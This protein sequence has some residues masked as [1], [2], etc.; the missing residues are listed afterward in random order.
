VIEL[1]TAI[2]DVNELL[3]TADRKRRLAAQ[4]ARERG[5]DPRTV[6]QWL[7]VA[8]TR[9][10]RRRLDVESWRDSML[11]VSGKLDPKLGGPTTNLAAVDNNRRTVYAKISRHDAPLATPMMPASEVTMLQREGTVGCGNCHEP[12][13]M[14][15]AIAQAPLLSPKLGKISGVDTAGGEKLV[16]QQMSNVPA[17]IAP[18]HSHFTCAGVIAQ[19]LLRLCCD[20]GIDAAVGDELRHP[21]F[22]HRQRH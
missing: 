2:A 15:S 5:W 6:S 7:I 14:Q 16:A 18:R 3:G 17:T 1:K 22:Q 9:T 20:R 21:L 10:N 11:A 13:T 19:T 12:H 8:D 4:V